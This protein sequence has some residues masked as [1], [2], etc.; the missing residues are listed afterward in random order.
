[1]K[2]S[3][4]E[5]SEDTGLALVKHILASGCYGQEGF[6]ASIKPQAAFFISLSHYLIHLSFFLPYCLL[7]N[8]STAQSCSGARTWF[9]KSYLTLSKRKSVFNFLGEFLL[10]IRS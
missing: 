8:H 7:F 2:M 1:M 3:K 10:I 5:G 4:E 6:Q 9:S